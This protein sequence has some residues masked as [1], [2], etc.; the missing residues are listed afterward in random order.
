MSR[1]KLEDILFKPPRIVWHLVFWVVFISFF[2]LVYGSF[3]EQYG[4]QYLIQLTDAILQIPAVY[5]TLYFLMPRYLFKERYVEFIT[6]LVLLI[7]S[8]S[9]LHWFNYVLVQEPIFWSEDD[10]TPALI[11]FGKMLK[12]TTKVYPVLVLAIVIKWFKYWYREQKSNQQL[13]EEKLKAELNFLKAQVHPHFLFNT[14]NN[15]YALTLK[16]SKDAPEVVLKLSDL[17]NYMLYECTADQVLIEKEIKL[18]NDYISLEQIRYGDRLN[19]SFN[20]LGNA[21]GMRVA[22]LMLLPFVEN[23]FKHGVS[24]EMDEAW[25]SI[26]LELK[27][28]KLTLKVENSKS[29]H[30]ERDDQF[31]YKQGIGL[32]N[33]QRRLELLYPEKHSLEMHDSVDSFLIVLT[34]EL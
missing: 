31:N 20:I 26:D 2:S 7:L 34:L 19:I 22:P 16:K 30:E 25:V 33:V 3:E 1:I 18:L 12:N 17:L 14:L 32:K 15:L 28:E 21:G 10:Y 24:E 11:N 23:S 5:F 6:Y 29:K 8:F 13:V 9:A 4:R 27:E